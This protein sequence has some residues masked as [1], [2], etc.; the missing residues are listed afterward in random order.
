M[1]ER[2]GAAQG[3]RRLVQLVRLWRPQ[4]LRAVQRAA[5]KGAQRGWETSAFFGYGGRQPAAAAASSSKAWGFKGNG[6][7]STQTT[8][9][10]PPT[11]TTTF[12]YSAFLG[13]TGG[14]ENTH[15]HTHTR[16]VQQLGGQ[17]PLELCCAL[18]T[19][20]AT[21]E[22]KRTQ[23]G[24]RVSARFFFFCSSSGARADLRARSLYFLSL[25]L[26]VRAAAHRAFPP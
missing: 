7:T 4:Q 20:G 21:L 25:S 17:R 22:N 2:K 5:L 15:T 26:S 1:C 6:Q 18:C 23:G 11:T 13:A 24:G 10:P 3:Q 9:T 19:L 14:G 12:C 8:A 16:P